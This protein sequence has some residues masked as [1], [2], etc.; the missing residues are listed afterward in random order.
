MSP[1]SGSQIEWDEAELDHALYDSDG[2][3]GQIIGQLGEI[4]LAG[5]RRRALRRTGK[6]QD[7]MY[8]KV[9]R[10]VHGPAAI[11]VS[12]ARS[13]QGYPYPWVHE[14]RGK[15]R[16]RRPHRSLVPGL[17]DVRRYLAK[18]R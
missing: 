16:D 13:A 12:P 11:V 18:P 14:R 7:E 10:G 9:E 1:V 8:T 5:A 3:A 15:V 6:M 2:P 4:A 17:N